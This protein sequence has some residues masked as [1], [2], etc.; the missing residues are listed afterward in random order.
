MDDAFQ[1]AL[2][3]ADAPPYSYFADDHGPAPAW[4]AAARLAAEAAAAEAAADLIPPE[5]HALLA[6]PWTRFTT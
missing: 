6:E 2:A 5:M 4:E 3:S 1:A